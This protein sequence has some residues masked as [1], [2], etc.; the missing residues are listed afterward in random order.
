MCAA[1]RKAAY[2]RTAAV[3]CAYGEL[4]THYTREISDETSA[5]TTDGFRGVS[6]PS[7][8]LEL[9]H[10]LVFVQGNQ[11]TCRMCPY[12]TGHRGD[13]KKHLRKHTGERPFSCDHCSASFS[14]KCNLQHH[15]RTHT[16]ERP[17]KCHLC[18]AKFSSHG[19]CNRHIAAHSK[20]HSRTY[21]RERQ[22]EF[23]QQD[24]QA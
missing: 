16:G 5:I 11:H 18:P 15:I 2:M 23:S 7:G 20:G 24:N 8:S 14:L 6:L 12:S 17:F 19:T 22:D 13:M 4:R 10:S 21:R 9:Y 1:K 3:L